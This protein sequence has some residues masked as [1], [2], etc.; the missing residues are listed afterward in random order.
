[1]QSMS[2]PSERPIQIRPK[3]DHGEMVAAVDLG[4]NSFHMVIAR[5]ADGELQVVDR[6]KEMV[7]LAAGLDKNNNLEPDSR[8]RALATMRMFGERLKGLNPNNV[9]VVGTNTLRKARNSRD[10]LVRAEEAMGHRIEIVSGVEEA[11]LV[12]LGVAHSIGKMA[13][14]KRLVVDIG[15]GS[16]EVIIGT[17]FEAGVSNSNYMGCVSFSQRFFPDGEITRERFDAAELA[18]RQE[19]RSSEKNFIAEGW[20]L[21]I[22]ASGTIKAIHDIIIAQDLHRGGITRDAMKAVRNQICDLGHI[23]KLELDGLSER[24]RPVFPGGLAILMGVFKSLKIEEMIISD[25]AMREGLLYDLL[26]R[27]YQLDTRNDTIEQMATRYSVDRDHAEEVEAT[28]M[29]LF[30][31]VES[32]WHFDDSTIYRKMLRWT[33]RIHEIGLAIAHSGYHKHGSYLVEN[34]DMPGF[35]RQDQKFLWA[36]V[37]SH[38]RSFKTHRFDSLPE[39]YPVT[40]PRLAILLRLAVMLNRS[41]QETD[42]PEVKLKVPKN[43]RHKLKVRFPK[44]WL[45]EHPLTR[46]DLEEEKEYL[47]SAGF[48]LKFK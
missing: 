10:F 2:N 41:R 47:K 9:R 19:L 36:M 44:G 3:T 8:E 6:L 23:E 21:A 39:P 34:S 14:E 20:D 25:G 4:S 35:S 17:G 37:R 46:A 11:R 43:K 28:A 31:Q 18:A 38:R 42:V 48:K 27:M 12:Y 26:G 22:G 33:A 30:D 45:D 5:N 32:S 1:M 40:A 13:L 16:T 24:R 29:E 15:G 7:R